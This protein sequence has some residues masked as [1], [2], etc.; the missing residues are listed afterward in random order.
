MQCEVCGGPTQFVEQ[1]GQHWCEACKAYRG[2]GA[3]KKGPNLWLV[4]GLPIAGVAL[5]V[6]VVLFMSMR[7]FTSYM[8]KSKSSESQENLY[9]IARGA[10]V[11]QMTYGAFPSQPAGPTP[12]LGSCCEQGSRCQPDPSLW[13]QPPWVDLDFSIQRSHYYSYEYE[14]TAGGAS[15]TVRAYGDLDCD[16]NYSTFELV[17]YPDGPSASVDRIT[18]VDPLE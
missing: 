15:F 16:G 1:Y 14:P 2:A 5:V 11:Y 17:G 9:S 18:E 12:P 4:V 6:G 10:E 3:K 13:M 7:S 8:K